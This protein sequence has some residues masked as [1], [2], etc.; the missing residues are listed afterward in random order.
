MIRRPVHEHAFAMG[1]SY[2]AMDQESSSGKGKVIL[3]PVCLVGFDL[4][5][6]PR[7]EMASRG[8]SCGFRDC[9]DDCL[10]RKSTCFGAVADSN[11]CVIA[12]LALE[13]RRPATRRRFA[14]EGGRCAS[15]GSR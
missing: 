9:F 12:K 4:A 11:T 7:I 13:P 10:A 1:N 5:E 2:S 3:S 15:P 6:V 8:T 14:T